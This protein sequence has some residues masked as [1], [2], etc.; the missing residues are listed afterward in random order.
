M[1]E[2]TVQIFIGLFQIS[3]H[4][5]IVTISLHEYLHAFLREYEA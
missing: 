2:L 5:V 1:L 3:L 4:R